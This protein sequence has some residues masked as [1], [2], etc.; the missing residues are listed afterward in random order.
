L[1]HVDGSPPAGCPD[2][3]QHRVT[4]FSSPHC[5]RAYTPLYVALSQ[6]SASDA[7]VN[8]FSHG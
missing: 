8:V 1:Q 3:R 5:A 4:P 6:Q 2:F 7:H